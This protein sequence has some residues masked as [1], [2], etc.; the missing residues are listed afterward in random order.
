MEGGVPRGFVHLVLFDWPSIAS[1]WRRWSLSPQNSW[2]YLHWRVWSKVPDYCL[3]RLFGI[4]NEGEIVKIVFLQVG[5]HSWRVL[6]LSCYDTGSSPC[7]SELVLSF[8]VFFKS[9]WSRMRFVVEVITIGGGLPRF[10]GASSCGSVFSASAV[11]VSMPVVLR[12]VKKL[13]VNTAFWR[14]LDSCWCWD[15]KS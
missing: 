11:S 10:L 6:R 3:D 12:G 1:R 8:N 13:R 4:W 7:I 2:K 9:L 15:C 14:H 5:F